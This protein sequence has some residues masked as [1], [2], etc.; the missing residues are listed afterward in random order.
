MTIRKRFVVGACLVATASFT[1]CGPLFPSPPPPQV[2]TAPVDVRATPADAQVTV[3]WN[4]GTTGP[5][6]NIYWST[7]SGAGLSGTKIAGATNPFVHAGLTNERTYYYVV[8]AENGSGES[9]ASAQVMATPSAYLPAV[10]TGVQATAGYHEVT[11]TWNSAPRATSYNIYWAFSSAATGVLGTKIADVT[12]PFV[13]TELSPFGFY[14]YVVTAV[15]EVGESGPSVEVSAMP[16]IVLPPTPTG[17]HASPGNA[18]VTISWSDVSGAVAYAI[19]WST[20]PGSGIFGT[21][22]W[23]S[24]NP[25]VHT[26]LINGRAYYYVVTAANTDGESPA[27]EQ[28]SATP[29]AAP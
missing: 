22:I 16:L 12:S 18:Q 19:Y 4:R 11:I 8:T 29:S 17:V 27:S 28:V 15:N 23:A 13:H 10:P 21:K 1:A 2:P 7:S 9:A 26:G 5:A 3:T 25:Y 6:F 20:T 14:S 24:T